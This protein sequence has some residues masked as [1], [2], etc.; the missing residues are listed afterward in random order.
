MDR[1]PTG[2]D[3]LTLLEILL[4]LAL[5]GLTA[6]AA[7]SALHAVVDT[8][9]HAATT[10]T[11]LAHL[12]FA[13]SEAVRRGHDVT[14]CPVADGNGCG[15]DWSRGWRVVL[16]DDTDTILRQHTELH[17]T[18][19]DYNRSRLSLRY[20][21]SSRAGGTFSLCT[22]S[23]GRETRLIVS[24]SGRVRHESGTKAACPE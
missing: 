24:R 2:T 9:R 16:G 12:H 17:R 4:V 21:G 14:L 5:I 23:T 11:L 15:S 10:N 7:G 6:T 8:H 20:D 19:L 1:R 3:G 22:R 18:R 13:R